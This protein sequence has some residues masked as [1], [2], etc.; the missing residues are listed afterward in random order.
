[1]ILMGEVLAGDG[2]L[3]ILIDGSLS[4]LEIFLLCG[5]IVSWFRKQNCALSRRQLFTPGVDGGVDDPLPCIL[6]PHLSYLIKVIFI[7]GQKFE[8]RL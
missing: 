5:P 2:W 6:R 1:M 4:D 8:A 3:E 7:S